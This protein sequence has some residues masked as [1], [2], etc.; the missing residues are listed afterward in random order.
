MKKIVVVVLLLVFLMPV[1]VSPVLA[2]EKS[3]TGITDVG[4]KICPVMG[5]PVSGKD[6]VV[7]QGKRY[8]LCC[9]AC[10]AAFL[11]HPEKY[12]SQTA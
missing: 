4:N 7:Y 8:G 11:A 6:F 12:A 1:M 9:P 5:G 10:K 3:E 2:A